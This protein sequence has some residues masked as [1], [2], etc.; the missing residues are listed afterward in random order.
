MG[1]LIQDDMLRRGVPVRSLKHKNGQLVI[2][3]AEHILL[4]MIHVFFNNRSRQRARMILIFQDFGNL[5]VHAQSI[6]VELA[7]P[8]PAETDLWLSNYLCE[9][10]I[11]SMV[12]YIRI[13]FELDLYSDL[14]YPLAL[15]YLD[16]LYGR[17]SIFKAAQRV[18]LHQQLIAAAK[19]PLPKRGKNGRRVKPQR[20]EVPP[21]MP[22]P[23]DEHLY[24][25][26]Q[27]SLARG[28]ARVSANPRTRPESP[29]AELNSSA[30]V[31]CCHAILPLP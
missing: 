24:I 5:Q 4:N 31:H 13:G 23:T 25:E 14:E 12:N 20:P 22:P 11:Q 28:L 8:K 7:G 26:A 9:V 30:T 10:I 6:D 1:T 16:Y 18:Y 19:K 27:Q 3:N 21:E 29:F 2:D 15:W 17:W